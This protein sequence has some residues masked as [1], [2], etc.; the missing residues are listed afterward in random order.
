MHFDSDSFFPWECLGPHSPSNELNL[1]ELIE[2]TIYFFRRRARNRV[3]FL[4]LKFFT[5]KIISKF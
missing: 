3:K 1:Q 4:C 2:S 5:D